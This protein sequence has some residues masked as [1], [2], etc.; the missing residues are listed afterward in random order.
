MGTVTAIKWCHHTFN[1]WRGCAKVSPGCTNCYAEALAKR[2]RGKHGA[3]GDGGTRV[4]ATAAWGDPPNWNRA[5]LAA[6]E[7]RR[8][9]CASM[10]DVFEDRPELVAPRERLFRLIDVTRGLDWLLL[11]KRPENLA[12]MLPAGPPACNV[13][14]GVSVEDR[15]HGLPRI[16]VL[17][18]VPA[19][20]RFLSCEPL[21]EDLGALDLAGLGWVIAGGESGPRRREMDLA[22]L[23][24][25]VGQCREAGVPCFVKQD[26]APES[27]MQGAI[28]DDVWAVKEFPAQRPR[29]AGGAGREQ[30]YEW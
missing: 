9:F 5:A 4:V 19:A 22:W 8:V 26:A 12:R 27:G 15:R 7:R 14:L 30:E 18:Q 28:P 2:F 10:A 21:L 25:I 24:S 20:L 17:R 1:P 6:G 23:L 3:W 11:T 16:D 13:W 29:E